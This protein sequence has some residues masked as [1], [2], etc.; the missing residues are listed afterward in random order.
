MD[1]KQS[2]QKILRDKLE[3]T[4][5]ELLKAA[6][7]SAL[8]FGGLPLAPGCAAP[9]EQVI[10]ALCDTFIPGDASVPGAGPG[11]IEGGMRYFMADILGRENLDLILQVLSL[12]APDFHLLSYPARVAVMEQIRNT[13]D[14]A[15]IF[16]GLH[17]A[18]AFAFY[19]ELMGQGPSPCGDPAFPGSFALIGVPKFNEGTPRDLYGCGET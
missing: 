16:Y 11:A 13:P 12:L 10:D 7:V 6:G 4:R 1:S 15:E 18:T 5:R 19:S 3:L 9:P 2:L 14:L 8:V 17:Q